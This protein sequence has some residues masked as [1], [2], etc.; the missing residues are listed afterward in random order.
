MFVA[1]QSLEDDDPVVI[2]K[3]K[4][5]FIFPVNDPDEQLC[6]D[7]EKRSMIDAVVMTEI[8]DIPVH[9]DEFRRLIQEL[10]DYDRT[11][12]LTDYDRMPD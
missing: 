8:K 2:P 4:I 10:T 9:R 5:R 12:E 3:E 7:V 6:P 11:Q 1:I